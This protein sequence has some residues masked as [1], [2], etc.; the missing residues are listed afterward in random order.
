MSHRALPRLCIRGDH[1]SRE[2]EKPEQCRAVLILM[3]SS[4]PSVS[5]S[6]GVKPAIAAEVE[7][8]SLPTSSDLP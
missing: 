5:L 3:G 8:A 1:E 6:V 7:I 4:S 2:R